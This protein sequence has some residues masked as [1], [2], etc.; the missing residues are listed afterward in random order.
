MMI[1]LTIG[2]VLNFEI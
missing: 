1:T 2:A